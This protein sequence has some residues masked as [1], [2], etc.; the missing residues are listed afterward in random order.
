MDLAVRRLH[1][2]ADDEGV[3]RAFGVG[4]PLEHAGDDGGPMGGRDPADLLGER[5]V[6]GLGEG[7]DRG[8][9]L[10]E[11]AGEGLRE[12]HQ[13]GV[14]GTQLGEPGPVV[15][16]VQRRSCLD[17]RDVHPPTLPRRWNTAHRGQ[18]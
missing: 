16:G 11:V 5:P 14:I 7:R 9:G 12:D 17:Q 6:E 1:R 3:E 15:G 4:G 8:A 18:S 10:P 2:S 13:V